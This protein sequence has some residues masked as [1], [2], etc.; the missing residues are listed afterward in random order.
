[1]M[2][3]GGILAGSLGQVIGV[4]PGRGIG[5]MFIIA[6]FGMWLATLVM[7]LYPRLRLVEDELP[8]MVPDSPQT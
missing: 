1:M 5:L 3:S 2:A 6:G 8:D 4:G 7:V